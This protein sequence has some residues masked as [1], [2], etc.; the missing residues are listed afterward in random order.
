M[1]GEKADFMIMKVG[2]LFKYVPI[3][4]KVK[5]NKKRVA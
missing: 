2:D 4:S 3:V 1:K 5:L